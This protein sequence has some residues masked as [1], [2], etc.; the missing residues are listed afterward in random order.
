MALSC[1]LNFLELNLWYQGGSI[2]LTMLPL[3]VFA[4]RRGTGWGVLAGLVFGTIKCTF[5]GGLS[6]GWQSILLDFIVAFTPLGLA[7]LFRGKSWGI[8]AGTVLGCV[9]R[10]IVHFISGI[11]IYAITV[12]TELFNATYTS[13]WMYSLV[14]NGSYVGIDMVLCLVIFGFLYAPLK[15]YFTA[16]DLNK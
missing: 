10:F 12:P 16:E 14:Y 13:P 9:G 4:W 1:A 5:D 8:F 15:K 7:G 6:W 2:G 3:V 11:T